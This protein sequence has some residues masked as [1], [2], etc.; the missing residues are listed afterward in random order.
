MSLA[1][2]RGAPA[3]AYPVAQAEVPRVGPNA[4][5]QLA[6]ALRAAGQ[7]SL[8]RQIFCTAGCGRYLLALPEEMVP[9]ADVAALH[10]AL[11]SL[12]PALEANRIAAAAG[13]RTGDYILAN[14]IPRPARWVLTSLPA[15][16]AV[17]M[18]AKAVCRHA[19]TFCGSG[20]VT[21]D[22][23]GPRVLVLTIMGNALATPACPWHRAVF[24][25]LFTRLGGSH[26]QVTHA[27]CC[28]LGADHCR[29][30]IR[31]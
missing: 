26:V 30:A 16:L 4:V 12:V 2:E 10:R 6:A 17:P 9:E 23:A 19:W 29:F 3:P 14:R 5:I 7:D 13:R 15:F 31:F 28:A 24:E 1:A 25:T 18:L 21:L 27:C 11:T 8:M 22:R 20:T